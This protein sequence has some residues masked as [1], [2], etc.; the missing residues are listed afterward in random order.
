MLTVIVIRAGINAYA[1]VLANCRTASG[2]ERMLQ[3]I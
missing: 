2:S 3:A 1:L